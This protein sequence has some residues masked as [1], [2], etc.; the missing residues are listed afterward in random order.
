MKG[1]EMAAVSE[2]IEIA[3]PANEVFAYAT[4]F[5]RFPEWQEGAASVH[6]GDDG[7][8]SVGSRAEVTRR[9]GPREQLRTEEI[10]ELSP[11]TTWAVRGVGGSATVTLQGTIEEVDAATARG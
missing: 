7:P 4:D 8:L 10:T 2:T 9:V 3:R 1:G 11:P 6:R 5:S